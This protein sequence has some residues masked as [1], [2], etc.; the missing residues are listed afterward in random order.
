M[1]TKQTVK[2]TVNGVAYERQVEP[3]L[4]L[5]DFLRHE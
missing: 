2:M 5:V 1:T 3:R 4:T